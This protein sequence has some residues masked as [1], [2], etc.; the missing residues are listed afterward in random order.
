MFCPKCGCVGD[1]IRAEG[2]N[3]ATPAVTGSVLRV[4]FGNKVGAA[5][6]VRMDG[7]MFAVM[8][9]DGVLGMDRCLLFDGERRVEWTVPEVAVAAP[10][11]RFQIADTNLTYWSVGGA[12][13]YDGG[14][15][16]LTRTNL[17]AGV[18]SELSSGRA[19]YR[20][21]GCEWQVLQPREMNRHGKMLLRIRA[22]ETV[23]LP[24]KTHPYYKYLESQWRKEVKE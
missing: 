12:M 11:A 23:E 14:Q 4:E 3:V 9:L 6:P 24:H 7:R 2:G 5:L 8:A 13:M 16:V 20:L 22:G 17:V 10:I 15:M 18:V 1:A 19:D 21:D